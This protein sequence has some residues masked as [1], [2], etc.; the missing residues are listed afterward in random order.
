MLQTRSSLPRRQL[1]KPE[2]LDVIVTLGSL[3]R[4]QLRNVQV[5]GSYA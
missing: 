4:R 2:M 3:P 5:G 1:R